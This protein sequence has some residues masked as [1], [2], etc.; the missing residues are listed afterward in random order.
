M[1][2]QTMTKRQATQAI[3]AQMFPDLPFLVILMGLLREL[4]LWM[5]W[6]ILIAMLFNT[7]GIPEL[8]EDIG[9]APMYALAYM[10]INRALRILL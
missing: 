10:V 1:K 3:L 5:V 2:K 6:F 7:K 4:F 8:R 9:N